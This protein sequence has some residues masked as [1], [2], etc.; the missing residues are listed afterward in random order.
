MAFRLKMLNGQFPVFSRQDNPSAFEPVAYHRALS[1]VYLTVLNIKL[2]L[3]PLYLSYDWQTSAVEPIRSV[4]DVRNVLS[5]IL[6]LSFG[7]VTSR[8]AKR[9]WNYEKFKNLFPSQGCLALLFLVFSYL[10]ASNLF[11]TVG[12]VLAERTLYMPR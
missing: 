7:L 3:F 2:L 8:L 9:F 1:F 5:L 4:T 6:V 10:P 11:V 12:F